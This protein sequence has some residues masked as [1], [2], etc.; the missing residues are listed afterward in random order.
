MDKL[1]DN[2]IIIICYTI[3]LIATV[4]IINIMELARQNHLHNFLQQQ[5]GDGG[6]SFVHLF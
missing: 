1:L 5:A 6:I 3:K 4:S 2:D